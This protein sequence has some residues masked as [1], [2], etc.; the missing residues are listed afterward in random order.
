M[1]SR[2]AISASTTENPI[3]AIEAASGQRLWEQLGLAADPKGEIEL[4]A[5]AAAAATG[6][7]NMPFAVEWADDV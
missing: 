6:A 5:T 2:M 3:T 7:G 4:I 1:P